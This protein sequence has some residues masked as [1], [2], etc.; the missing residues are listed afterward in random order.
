MK[1]I[2]ANS[3][4]EEAKDD[5]ISQHTLDPFHGV[6]S[7]SEDEIGAFEPYKDSKAAD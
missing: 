2:A 1:T 5:D 3:S 7:I 6:K 4:I